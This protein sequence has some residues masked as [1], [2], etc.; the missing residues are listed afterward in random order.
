MPTFRSVIVGLSS[1]VAIGVLLASCAAAPD[2][3]KT[4]DAS[5]DLLVSPACNVTPRQIVGAFWTQPTDAGLEL[6]T[7]GDLAVSGDSLFL[8]GNEGSSLAAFIWRISIQAGTY[9][10]FLLLNGEEDALLLTSTRLVVAESHAADATN[11]AGDVI[12]VPLS[13][14]PPDVL[15]QTVNRVRSMVADG[16]VIY[17]A[18][19][20]G[21]QKV[22]PGDGGSQV[23]SSAIGTLG[24]FKQDLIIADDSA[25]TLTSV[26]AG[27]GPSGV[28]ATNQP[29]A[30]NPLTCGQALCW[31][32]A[33]FQSKAQGVGA[34]V[35]MSPG[36]LPST[37]S[38]G[39]DLFLPAAVSFDGQSFFWGS[40]QDAV[41]GLS[42]ERVPAAGGNPVFV[43]QI[44]TSGLASDA[45]CLYLADYNDGVFAVSK[46]SM[47]PGTSR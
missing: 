31:T 44:R 45:R 42:V 3:A 10:T 39:G 2:S 29:R 30:A 38:E 18:D 20:N 36:G 17:F 12:A 47:I 28:L 19:G 26:P 7:P 22:V 40:G 41:S 1:H 24:V 6:A 25:G 27:G 4:P 43:S 32:T 13:G 21:S 11:F 8:A 15:A 34:I 5:A 35:K 9:T 33:V 37:L 23:L 14:G 46:D 16:E